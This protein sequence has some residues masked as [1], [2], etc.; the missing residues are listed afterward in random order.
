MNYEFNDF[1]NKD[2]YDPP[3]WSRWQPDNPL[4]YLLTIVFFLIGL[5]F[6]FGY[7]LTPLGTVM[8]LLFIDWWLYLKE[9]AGKINKDDYR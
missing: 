6:L 7:L 8:Q 3:K 2:P 5:P 4:K 1:R 9:Q